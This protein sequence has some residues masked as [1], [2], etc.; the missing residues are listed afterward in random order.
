M[1]KTFSFSIKE[2]E[3]IAS[4]YTYTPSAAC[5]QQNNRSNLK[6]DEKEKRAWLVAILIIAWL[7][8][9]SRSREEPASAVNAVIYVTTSVG[10]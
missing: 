6:K 4:V 10:K 5:A 9:H 2:S 3:T 8:S 1:K 7:Y